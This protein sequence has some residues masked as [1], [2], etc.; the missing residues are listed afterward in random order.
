MK[1]KGELKG[2]EVKGREGGEGW[3]SVWEESEEEGVGTKGR[4]RLEC[5]NGKGWKGKG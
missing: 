5:M 2:K 1:E 4:E 3:V